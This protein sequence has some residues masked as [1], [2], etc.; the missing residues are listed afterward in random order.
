MFGHLGF[1]YTGGK[2]STVVVNTGGNFAAGVIDTSG[3]FAASSSILVGHLSPNFPK[4]FL[5]DPGVI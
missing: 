1:V 3:K 2:F 5:N 4:K